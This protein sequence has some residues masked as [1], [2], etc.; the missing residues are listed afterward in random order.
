[1][2]RTFFFPAAYM[3]KLMLKTVVARFCSDD[4]NS[5]GVKTTFRLSPYW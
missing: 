1:M 4:R 5:S 2:L 3:D